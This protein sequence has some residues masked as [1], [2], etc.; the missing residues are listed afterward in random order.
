MLDS[1]VHEYMVGACETNWWTNLLFVSNW[2]EPSKMCLINTWF[3][4][5][6]TQLYMASFFLLVIL[7][8]SPRGGLIAIGSLLFFSIVFSS[9]VTVYNEFSPTILTDHMINIK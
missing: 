2:I 4:S 7:H 6:D 5:A 1:S 3:V 8:R 9:A